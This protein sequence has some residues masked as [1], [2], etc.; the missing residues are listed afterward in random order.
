MLEFLNATIRDSADLLTQEDCLR[1]VTQNVMYTPINMDRETGQKKKREFAV[2]VLTNDLF[3][4][5]PS[6]KKETILPRL[7]DKSSYTGK[8]W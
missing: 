4:H 5:C 3:P 8:Y 2:D 7:Y 6:E 1:C